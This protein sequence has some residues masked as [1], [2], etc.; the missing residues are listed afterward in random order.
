MA[1]P[2]LQH[3]L[4][5]L[6]AVASL[7]AALAAA[8]ALNRSLRFQAS[9]E[10]DAVRW[11]QKSRTQ[12]FTLMMGGEKPKP[13]PLDAKILTRH[14]A[15][16]EP[17]S[18]EEVS[19]QT[20][21][22]RRVHAWLALPKQQTAKTGA[23][24][25]LHGHGGTGAQVVRGQELYW[26]GRTLTEMGYVVIAPDI[27]SHELQHTN[28]TLMGERVW[29]ALRCVDYLVTRPE[30][31]TN[32]L[33]V[34]G[35]SLGGETT[36]YVAAL[37]ERLK[38]VCS[39]GWLTT[40]ENMK[41]G[42]CPCWNFPGLEEHF[43]FA[44]IFAC[45]APRPM[46]LEVGEKERAPGGFPVEIARKAFGEIRQAYR[47]F[48]A[49]NQVQLDAHPGGHV[50]HGAR[51][52][53]P[54]HDALGPGV[55]A[56]LDP[57]ET[58][59]ERPYEM[60]WV[61]RSEPTLPT[62]R[63]DQ[64]AGW[65]VEL[66]GGAEARLQASRAQNLWNRPVGK[67]RYRGNGQSGSKPQV[68]LTPAHP[69]AIPSDS[70]SVDLWVY[71]NRWDWENPPDTPGVRIVLHLRDSEGKPIECSV[72]RVRWKEWW[73]MH[74]RLPA[75]LRF[76]VQL[77]RIEISGGWQKDWRELYFDSIRF[78][79]EELPTLDFAARPR[80][81]LT[82]FEGQ[83]P[84]ANTGPGKLPF[85]TREQ[86]I[87][88]MHF[89]GKYRN[90]VRVG[91]GQFQ[92]VYNGEDCSVSYFFDPV[93][94]LGSI[95]AAVD[96]GATAGLVG[97]S[98]SPRPSPSGRGRIDPAASR[99]PVPLTVS[100]GENHGSLSL[101][102][103]ARVRGKSASDNPSDQKLGDG[104]AS[105]GVLL[106]GAA[107][108]SATNATNATL[109]SAR[110]VRGVVTAEYSDGTTLRLQIWQ[111]SLVI[112]VINRTGLATDLNFGQLAGASEARL[113][114]VPYLHYG[115]GSHPSVLLSHAGDQPVFTS[116]WPDW[117]RS[118]GSE[119]Y[120]AESAATNSAR[121]NGGVRYHPRTDGRRNPMFERIF[122]TV[123]P[124]FEEVLPTIPT[125]VGRN[126]SQAV[127]R[128]W[129]E[130]WGPD[131]YEKQMRRSRML[132]AYG[133]EKLIQC[134]HE[135]TWRDGGE[136][137]TLRVRAAPK[138]GGDEGLA[139]YLA[140]QRG[141][142]WFAGL[143][144]NY[145]DYAPVNEFWTPDS[146]Q[147]TPD[148]NWKSAWP[149]CW[150]LKPLKAVE[151]DALL[152]PQIKAKFN[153]NSAYTDVHTA[154][155]PWGYNDYDAR[156]PGA[157]TF[158]QT[159][160]AYGE[161]LRSDS[162][163]YG[164]PIF[165]EGTYQWLYAGLADGNYALA[166]DGRPLAKEPLLPVFDLYQIHSK[167]CD[168]GMGWTANF[169]DAIPDWRKPANLD[170]S[171]DRF[172][173]HTL[174]FGHI[175]WLVEE[176]HGIAR[177]CRSYYMLQQV[178]VRYGLKM[179]KRIGYWD[180]TNLCSV[181][182]ALVKDLPRNRRQLF[183][184]YPGGLQLWLND[185]PSETWRAAL[186]S[187]RGLIAPSQEVSSSGIGHRL[188]PHPGPLPLGEGMRQ[189]VH[190]PTQSARLVESRRTTLPLPWGDGR[191]VGVAAVVHRQRSSLEF[192]SSQAQNQKGQ[193]QIRNRPP[194]PATF[195]LDLPP[196]GWA[197]LTTD[198]SLL[199]F[200]ALVGTNKVDYLRSPA[201]T[202]LD[203]RGRE[204]STAE[205]ASDGGLAISSQGRNQLQ[206]IR[207]SGAGAF[208]IRRPYKTRG[209]LK[210]CEA[211]DSDGNRLTTPAF[212]DDG[213]ESRIEPVDKA[214]RYVLS[215][216]AKP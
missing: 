89:G 152:A 16:A 72:D 80:R 107:V 170:R 9:N 119:P 106:D 140:H 81:N 155:A 204:F 169:C 134:N 176:E 196:A 190:R 18:L 213:K 65:K 136:S 148:R 131:D 206:V 63:F 150:A 90:E 8:E 172:L 162:R 168:I 10:S 30:V 46:V 159:F 67:V 120:A 177:A 17:Y 207:I 33:A 122:L 163:V 112:D 126:A 6:L 58:A 29:D 47:I 203:G 141:L 139:R 97:Y 19:L 76:P 103:R 43:D 94:G 147:R 82:L 93:K 118:N 108:R 153:P 48:G 154:V 32:R 91:D 92:F 142:G 59:G 123:S 125:P 12:L 214:V 44:D 88:P 111:K 212:Q 171:I 115:G 70:D 64:L 49:E 50:F 135:I 24:L 37:D 160:Y 61:N 57:N 62:V 128:L 53:E 216:D 54:L 166:Y 11:Q 96:S 208:T 22:D 116:I 7:A 130:S 179:P 167:E 40:V 144:S 79:R 86:T 143:Y 165:S 95:E 13:V 149:R 105:V 151:L 200:S 110:L 124:T 69:I 132:R 101:G 138:K 104:G 156:V 1:N 25:A 45:V 2:L 210:S 23:I 27:G 102:E 211:Y 66:S 157:G 133:I 202:Y 137:F 109:K 161:L 42:H 84:G 20:L 197:A 198:G 87:L 41:R 100:V 26:Y 175:G 164:G 35:L 201:Y 14:E 98:P 158:A 15:I 192:S 146:V 78:Y 181:S 182:E 188:P 36:M 73:L 51:F 205:A 215:F 3:A 185:H 178:Q 38:V 56:N 129:Q 31:D 199:S 85:P 83:S 68:H 194:A 34:A 28:W 189:T 99:V 183:I 75:S 4:H 71:G 117:Y 39:S 209:A 127:D 21:P 52:W 173:L 193:I 191:G 184:E 180:G 5:L 195:E 187:V 77:V 186:G 174:A 121:I 114:T 55:I 113:I 60:V 145:T 74:R